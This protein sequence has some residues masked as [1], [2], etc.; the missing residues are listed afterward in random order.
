VSLAEAFEAT[1]QELRRRT[2]SILRGVAE[3]APDEG[4]RFALEYDRPGGLEELPGGLF[5]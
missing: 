5:R 4:G 1:R 3:A 2:I